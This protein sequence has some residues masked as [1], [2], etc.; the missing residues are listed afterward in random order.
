MVRV[1]FSEKVTF[2]QTSEQGEGDSYADIKE[3][4]FQAEKIV[5]AKAK[6]EARRGACNGSSG[7]KGDQRNYIGSDHV[8]FTRLP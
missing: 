2:Q 6:E 4:A 5:S 7:R 1:V 3:I 8:I